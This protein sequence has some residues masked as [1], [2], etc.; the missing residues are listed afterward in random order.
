MRALLVVNPRATNTT[1]RGRDVLIRALGSELKLDVVQTERRGHAVSLGRQAVADGMDVVVVLGGDGTVNEVAGGLLAHGP[2]PDLPLV[3]VVPGGSTNVFTRALGL[4]R[5]PVE[6]TS[7]L[8]DGLHAGRERLIGV[9]RAG[10]R[11]FL[12]NAGVGLDAQTVRAIERRRR[13][14]RGSPP[15]SYVRAAAAEWL[16]ATDRRRPALTLDRPGEDP[17]PGLHL[18]FVTV[19][20]PWTYLGRLPVHTNPAADFG[21]GLFVLALRRLGPVA[22]GRT[23][24]GMLRG[25]P[26]GRAVLRLEGLT[27]CTVRADRPMAV[28]VDGDYLGERET[29]EFGW[30]PAALRVVPPAG[31]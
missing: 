6:A 2:R 23:G 20:S 9:G 18:A 31:V 7:V 15:A 8:L 14:G 5:D 19:A 30:L 10:D 11:V 21:S 27:A 25:R 28:Q 4:P 1:E 22:T 24:F 3:A 13:H 12:F 17:V 26:R 16:W 29:V